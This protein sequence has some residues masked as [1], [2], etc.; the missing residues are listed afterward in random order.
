MEETNLYTARV[1]L[2]EV[3]ER[4]PLLPLTPRDLQFVARQDQCC[5]D[6]EQRSAEEH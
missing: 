3:M 5:R 4:G 6:G 1:Q 2:V